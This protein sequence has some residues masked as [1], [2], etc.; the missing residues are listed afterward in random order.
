MHL[1]FSTAGLLTAFTPPASPSKPS[2]AQQ[3]HAPI[4]SG[5]RVNLALVTP[6]VTPVASPVKNVYS[7]PRT[8]PQAYYIVYHGR[9]GMQGLFDGW[10]GPVD[11]IGPD[12]LCDGYEH[13]ISK[14]FTDARKAQV[15]YD[16]CKESGVLDVLQEEPTSDEILFVIKGA[17]PGVYT[18]R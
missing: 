1:T 11:D 14:K 15:Y 9:G 13:R 6:A 16:E 17:Q 7:S 8:V 4:V 5:G 2:V 18:K 12:S 10:K 3:S